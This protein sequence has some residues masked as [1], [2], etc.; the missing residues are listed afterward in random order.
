M[1]SRYDPSYKYDIGTQTY[2]TSKKRRTPAW[3]DRIL[4]RGEKE[5]V[6]CSGYSRSELTTSDH[7]PVHQ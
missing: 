4:W 5:H 3:C 1:V 6:A 7:R 2:D